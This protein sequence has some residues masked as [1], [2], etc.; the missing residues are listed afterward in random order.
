[1]SE[2]D[3]SLQKTLKENARLRSEREESLREVA[4]TEYS[5]RLRFA[6]RIYWFYAIVCVAIGVAAINYFTH[7]YDTKS[8]ITCAV[9]ILV[10]YETTV[11][12]KLWFSTATM[13]MSVLKDLKL[14]RLEVAR[15]ATATGVESPN[16]PQVKYEPMRGASPLERRLWL[17]ACVVVAISVSTWTKLEW[18]L[19]GGDHSTDTRVTLSADGSATK[20]TETVKPYSNFDEPKGFSILAGKDWSVRFLD[21]DGQDM[22]VEITS[23]DTHSRHH[24]SFTDGV[25]NDGKMHYTQV[26]DIPKAATLEDGVWTYQ[27]GIQHV[28]KERHFS[29][30]ILPPTDAKLLSAEPT[31]DVDVDKDGR[32]RL[33]FRGTAS[34]NRK[35]TFTIRYELPLTSEQEE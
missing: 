26:S 25:Y 34:D 28:G 27:E 23:T 5:G 33:R 14:L 21:S 16:E 2:H 22:P 10:I 12:M 35:F 18:Q 4:S 20:R 30:T 24:V 1:M 11:L 32:T 3:D 31:P 29:I 7:S 9:I 6:E 19:G 8:L 17:A 13:K 15:L